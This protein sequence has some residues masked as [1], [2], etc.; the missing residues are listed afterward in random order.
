MYVF[1]LVATSTVA[2]LIIASLY[3]FNFQLATYFAD[4]YKNV[5]LKLNMDGNLVKF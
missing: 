4:F 1:Y 3:N 5:N 2:L